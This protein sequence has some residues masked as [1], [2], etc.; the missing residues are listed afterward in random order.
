MAASGSRKRLGA[1]RVA[2]RGLRSLQM[3]RPRPGARSAARS[4]LRRLRVAILPLPGQAAG[5]AAILA[6]LAAALVS[7]PLMAGAA[8]EGAWQLQRTRYAEP[9]LGVQ[10]ASTSFPDRGRPTPTRITGVGALD[11][12][13]ERAVAAAGLPTPVFQMVLRPPWVTPTRT[14][15]IRTQLVFR[16]GAEDHVRI[17]AGA[18]S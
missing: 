2:D 18:A 7:L 3:T 11:D 17:T 9:E 10:L 4:A 1:D 12:Q 14:E 8:E 16:T 5:L 6:V 15:A 13:V